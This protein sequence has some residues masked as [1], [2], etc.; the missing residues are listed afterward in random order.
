MVNLAYLEV[1]ESQNESSW[2]VTVYNNKRSLTN[3]LKI[4]SFLSQ[5]NSNTVVRLEILC[6]TSCRVVKV[7]V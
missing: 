5:K 3:A 7:D 6:L 4:F 1:K 2:N